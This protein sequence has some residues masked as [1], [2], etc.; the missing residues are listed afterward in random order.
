[1]E[2]HA[3]ARGRDAGQVKEKLRA[4]EDKIRRRLGDDV[5]GAD[6]DRMTA[7]VGALLC[8]RGRTVATAESCTAGMLGAALTGE[9]GSSAWFRGGVIVYDDELKRSLAGVRAETLET[10][11]AV[12]EAVARELAAGVRERCG[13]D[14][15]IGITGIAGPGGGSPAKPVGRVHLAI[16]DGEESLHWRLQLIGDRTAVRARAVAT[17][18]DRLRRRL[19]ERP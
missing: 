3:R 16:Q 9:A 5:Y 18:L 10:H 15:G 6:E 8:E 11:G 12:S 14:L 13:A 2:L 19:M 7:V 17:A 4:F 1:V